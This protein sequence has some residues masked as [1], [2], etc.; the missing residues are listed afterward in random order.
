MRV[1]FRK[2]EFPSFT[3]VRERF[4]SSKY[5]EYIDTFLGLYYLQLKQMSRIAGFSLVRFDFLELMCIVQ[6]V[7][8]GYAI[9]LRVRID[10]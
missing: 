1:L 5:V 8:C 6:R 10:G 9:E 4:K 2:E 3:E 7:D